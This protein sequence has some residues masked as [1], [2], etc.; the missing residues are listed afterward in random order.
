LNNF[1]EFK[2]G[3]DLGNLSESDVSIESNIKHHDLDESEAICLQEP[4]MEVIESIKLEFNDDIL[5]V[6][7]ESLY[8]S[9]MT[10]KVLMRV[11]VLN[12]NLFHLAPPKLTFFLNIASLNLLSLRTLSLR[13]LL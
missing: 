11:S 7:Y 9:L 1:C 10:M 12:M 13:I 5:F 2:G 3:D 4:Y 8:V 6:E